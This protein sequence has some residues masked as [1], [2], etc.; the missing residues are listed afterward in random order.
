MVRIHRSAELSLKKRKSDEEEISK[1][2]KDKKISE[3]TKKKQ[4]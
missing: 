3:E 1:D 4:K 2:T